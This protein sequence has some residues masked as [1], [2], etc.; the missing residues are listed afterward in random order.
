MLVLQVNV[1]KKCAAQLARDC[2]IS[3]N[4]I[5]PQFD[6]MSVREPAGHM[7]VEAQNSLGAMIPLARLPGS[8]N[9]R[10]GQPGPLCEGWLVHFLLGQPARRLK[11]YWILHNGAISLYNE[12]SNGETSLPPRKSLHLAGGGRGDSSQRRSALNPPYDR[13]VC[14]HC[15]PLSGAVS[16]SQSVS[17]PIRTRPLPPGPLTVLSSSVRPLPPLNHCALPSVTLL[18]LQ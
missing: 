16:V 5:V 6:Q 3:G 2:R 8:A 11:H 12:Y 10:T 7:E 17:T 14:N 9:A 13:A 1:H 4:G 18:W 15:L